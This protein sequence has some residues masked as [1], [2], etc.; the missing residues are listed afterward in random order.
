MVVSVSTDGGLNWA[1]PVVAY[2]GYGADKDPTQVFNDKEWMVADTNP[3]SPYYGRVYLTWSRFLSHNG[4]YDESPIWEPH[5]DDGGLTWSAGTGDLGSRRV[6]HVP[7][8]RTGRRVR[9]G[10]GI[11]LHRRLRTARSTWRS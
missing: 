11:H 5:S 1:T 6:L 8:R 7:D 9:R 4:H 3:A 2:Q 10:P